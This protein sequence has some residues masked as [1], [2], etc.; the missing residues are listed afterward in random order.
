MHKQITCTLL[1]AGMCI[2]GGTIAIPIVF[3]KLGII[4]S[5]LVTILVWFLN[6]YPSLVGTELNLRSERG[7]SLGSLGKKFSGHGAQIAGEIS[8]K[9]LSYAALTMYL[10]GASS[11]IQKLLEEC[12]KCEISVLMIETCLAIFGAILLFFPFKIVSSVN[13]LMFSGFVFIFAILLIVMLKF[14]DYSTM[15]WIVEPTTKDMLSVCP[16]IF[17]SFG[18]Q[19]VLHTMRDYCGKDAITLQRSIFVGSFAP[20]LVYVVWSATA[21]GAIFKTNPEFFNQMISGKIE[22]GEFVKE[23]ANI[24]SFSNFQILVW[25]MSIL[26]ILT[27]YVGVGVGLA[28]SLN[29]TFEKRIKSE[30]IKKIVA[31]L[32]T[33]LPAYVIAA[34]YPDAFIKILGFAGAMVATIGVLIPTYL[35]LKIGIGEKPY[36]KELK[37]WLL[38][39]CVVGGFIIMLT[40]FFLN[41]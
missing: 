26:A 28:E 3:A 10:C 38:L 30:T 9:V 22:V 23:L 33:I 14:T 4:P 13:N 8:V 29:L 35:I 5:A 32:T 34:I 27:S 20:A 37:K 6:Y 36:Y 18:Y 11:I 12:L 24:S 40:E 19:L 16:V 7:L 41:N 25:C 21:L 17:A 39:L 15:P 2:G 1:V 31:S